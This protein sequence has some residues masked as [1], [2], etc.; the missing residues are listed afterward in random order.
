VP[1]KIGSDSFETDLGREAVILIKG[2]FDWTTGS[3]CISRANP[4]VV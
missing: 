4:P 3:F 2:S 1:A